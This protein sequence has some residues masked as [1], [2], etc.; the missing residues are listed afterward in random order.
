MLMVEIKPLENGAH[1]NQ[2]GS[3]DVAIP[4]GWAVVPENLEM[5]ARSYLPFVDLTV[6]DGEIVSVS[7]G[8]IPEPGPE[9]APEPTTEDDLMTM[10][11]DHECRLTL[12]ELGVN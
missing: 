1:R 9:P 3:N 2:M 6:M 7:Q 5:E 11:V 4:D 12:L 8:T 10:A